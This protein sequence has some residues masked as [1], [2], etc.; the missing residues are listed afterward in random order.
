MNS[1]LT[2]KLLFPA[3]TGLAISLSAMGD[4]AAPQLSS[5]G[6]QLLEKDRRGEIYANPDVDWSVY[7][8]IKLEEAS[9]AFRRNWQRDQNRYDPFKVKA[10][11][12]EKMK[13]RLSE[14]FGEVFTEELSKDNGY[15][16]AAGSGA[17]VL[18]IQPAIV[19]L[20]INAPDTNSSAGRSRQY[21][22]SAG[23]MTLKLALYDSVTGELLATAS[24]HRESPYR[25]YLQWTTSVSNQ[26]DARRMLRHWAT[27]LR[28]RLDRASSK[29]APAAVA[30]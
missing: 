12:M 11:D 1:L 28:E 18:T 15:V 26:A 20:D 7:T 6:L 19:D 24:D 4:D 3:L 14:L 17:N 9:V 21:T 2:R 22:E 25:G 8:E 29:P 10:S 13:K 30:E 16:M 27:S 5:E 23:E